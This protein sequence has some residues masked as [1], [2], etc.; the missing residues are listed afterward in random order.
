MKSLKYLATILLFSASTVFA[1]DIEEAN[2][3]FNKKDYITAL[4]K[5]KS[6]AL[7]NDAIGQLQVGGM[8]NEGLGVVQ[9]Y[10]EAVRWY[11]LAAA[12]GNS[13]A[14]LNLGKMHYNGQGVVQDYVRAHMWF[15]LSS[16][17]GDADAV[18]K[19]NIA[20]GKMTPQQIGEAQKME[21][22]CQARNF[23]NCD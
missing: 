17:S 9:D 13:T 20:A 15:N 10:A 8:Y 12:Q 16:V 19:R 2:A 4:K 23:K 22:E 3:A 5:F 6:A 11:K 21:R 1:G 7:K 18:K 14:Q